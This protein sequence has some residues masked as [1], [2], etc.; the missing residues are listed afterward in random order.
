[1]RSVR[2]GRS[3]STASNNAI[4]PSATGRA[5]ASPQFV[6]GIWLRIIASGMNSRHVPVKFRIYGTGPWIIGQRS[7]GTGRAPHI[8][9]TTA[10]SRSRDSAAASLKARPCSMISNSPNSRSA[11]ASGPFAGN[12]ERPAADA[13]P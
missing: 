11:V 5:G 6:T 2:R 9:S 7:R 10:A 1:M 8:V 3:L 13:T 4:A 12:C